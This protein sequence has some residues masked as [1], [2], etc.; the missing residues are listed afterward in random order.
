MPR[1]KKETAKQKADND[2]LLAELEDLIIE[3]TK[4]PL[5]SSNG[6]FDIELDSDLNTD[7]DDSDSYEDEDED[8]DE[9]VDSF[10]MFAKE[11]LNHSVLTAEQ[12]VE[13][14]NKMNNAKTEEMRRYWRN[15]IVNSNY[16]LVVSIV[17]KSFKNRI[18]TTLGFQD[19]VNEGVLGCMRAAD[20]FD[21]SM[22][23]KFSTYATRWI[24]KFIQVALAKNGGLPVPEYHLLTRIK[25]IETAF[26][27]KHSR[28]PTVSELAELAD[29]TPAKVELLLRAS[30]SALSL[31]QIY[32]TQAKDNSNSEGSSLEDFFPD[33]DVDV[34]ASV[35]LSADKAVLHNL[36]VTYLN[37]ETRTFMQMRYGLDGFPVLGYSK[38]A[39]IR[40]CSPEYVRQR[41]YKGTAL[42][43]Y[44][45]K[46]GHLPD[47]RNP[48][49]AIKHKTRKPRKTNNADTPVAENV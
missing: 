7:F 19:L 35:M 48:D 38:I 36:I 14:F 22:N 10:T 20:K 34:E 42:I 9:V 40:K 8:I 33:P 21:V 28:N 17:R 44:I 47:K 43:A 4:K 12:E 26:E 49:K 3:D 23:C 32:N 25:A 41:V 46:T 18:T 15:E 6:F 30:E 37:D 27:A 16:K 5:A 2:A 24:R 29:T 11:A 39:E 13:L 31:N 1:K 45:N